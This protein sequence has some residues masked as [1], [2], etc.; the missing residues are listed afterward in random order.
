MSS[1]HIFGKITAGPGQRNSPQRYVLQP[2]GH[3]DSGMPLELKKDFICLKS[4][5]Y[6]TECD[7]PRSPRYIWPL[8]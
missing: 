1:S 7:D 2:L 5:R 4:A 3:A 8:G 6:E